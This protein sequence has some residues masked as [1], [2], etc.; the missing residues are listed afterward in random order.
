MFKGHNIKKITSDP[1]TTCTE[2]KSEIDE[3]N[4]MPFLQKNTRS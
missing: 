2:S 3:Y 1:V 4:V